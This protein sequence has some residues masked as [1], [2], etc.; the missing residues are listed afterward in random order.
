MC[1]RDLPNVWTAIVAVIF[2]KMQ[3]LDRQAE[4]A[5]PANDIP[6]P[7]NVNPK[8]LGRTVALPVEAG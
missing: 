4:R 2:K 3:N 8:F 7:S 1:H 5:G 6:L